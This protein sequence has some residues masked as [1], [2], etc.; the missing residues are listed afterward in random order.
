MRIEKATRILPGKKILFI[1]FFHLIFIYLFIL[2]GFH[3]FIFDQLGVVART[4]NVSI[5]EA[6]A[7][8]MPGGYG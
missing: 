4:F 8:R 6:E 3:L 2:L 1:Y 7:G 5:H